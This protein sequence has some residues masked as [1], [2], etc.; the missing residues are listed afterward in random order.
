MKPI[1][2]DLDFTKPDWG[3]PGLWFFIWSWTLLPV[4]IA[5]VGGMLLLVEQSFP[6][7]LVA[8]LSGTVASSLW[9]LGRFA[10]ANKTKQ[11]ELTKLIA[12][13]ADR[14]RKLEEQLAALTAEPASTH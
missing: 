3:K 9:E 14:I 6:L 4:E 1:V 13:Q 2:V 5:C 12:D 7:A 8:L 11:D 10:R